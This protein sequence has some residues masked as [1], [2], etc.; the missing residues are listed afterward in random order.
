MKL[1]CY[2]VPKPELDLKDIQDKY[3]FAK[4]KDGIVFA[5]ADGA[6]QTL[7]SDKWSKHLVNSFVKKP[8]FDSESFCLF[9]KTNQ[10]K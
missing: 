1:Q 4:V 10:L 2:Q 9:A 5:L 8:S 3:D 7:H 6:S